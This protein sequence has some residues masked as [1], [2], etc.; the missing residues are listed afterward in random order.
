MLRAQL[1]EGDWDARASGAVLRREWFGM[2]DE[3]PAT[4]RRLRAWDLAATEVRL[5]AD[6]DWTAGGLVALNDGV[7][8]IADMRRLRA[9]PAA[10]EAAVKQAAEL[11]TRRVAVR[12]EQEPGASGV[13]TIDHYAR[14]VLVGFDFRGVRSSG[15]KM[16]Q[17]RILASAA[18]AGNVKLVRGPWVG[19]FLDECD[20]FGSGGTHDDQVNAVYLAMAELTR[21]YGRASGAAHVEAAEKESRWRR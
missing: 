4:A 10:V 1:R 6:P 7:W 3:V 15:S 2:V 14:Q 13:N 20:G 9:R 5:G 16:E 8:Y 18:E 12:M 21:L 11:D 17:A 19:A